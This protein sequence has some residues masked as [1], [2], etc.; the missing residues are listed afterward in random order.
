[1]KVR[2]RAPRH[3]PDLDQVV[4]VTITILEESGESGFRIETLME[5]TGIAK[6]S[7]YMA[8]GSRDGL[9]AAAR[10]RQFEAMIRESIG[11]I[12]VIA[13]RATSR[14]ELRADLRQIT[15]FVA[16]LS[17]TA[18]RVER[19]AIIAGTK[20]RPEF[21]QWL[22]E[23]QTRLSTEFAQIIESCQQRGFITRKHP[24]RMI[25]NVIQAVVLGRVIVGFDLEAGPDELARWTDMV[26][27]FF[28]QVLFTD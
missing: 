17:R 20:G 25:G 10:A 13:E 15:A 2:Q 16:D 1:V 9:I 18:Q 4:A 12:R 11:P 19:C 28:D 7:L 14:D 3:I 26:N 23:A 5:R 27:D 21:S 22:A 8:F 6:S 24:A